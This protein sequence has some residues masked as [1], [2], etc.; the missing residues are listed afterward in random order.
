MTIWNCNF[1][2]SPRI[3]IIC[4]GF[5]LL[6]VIFHIQR[7][8]ANLQVPYVT[9]LNDYAFLLKL[10]N[11]VILPWTFFMVNFTCKIYPQKS[12]YTIHD[13]RWWN[14]NRRFHAWF[15]EP[16]EIDPNVLHLYSS[17]FF[18]VF[19]FHTLNYLHH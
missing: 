13:S 7:W 9:S 8:E 17:F 16:S 10:N 5:F 6:D 18:F 14:C 2:Q 19:R 4:L 3:L 1:F 12:I 15:R 11:L